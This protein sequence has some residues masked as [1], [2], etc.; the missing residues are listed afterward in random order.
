MKISEKGEIKR[1]PLT[2]VNGNEVTV[3]YAF[4]PRHGEKPG[5][6]LK[7]QRILA[8]KILN[9]GFKNCFGMEFDRR[10]VEKGIHGKPFWKPKKGICFNVSNTEGLVVCAVAR[11][12]VGVDGEKV[13]KVRIPVVRRCCSLKEQRYILGKG[14]EEM[15]EAAY[16]RFFQIW[17]LK[18]SYIKMTGA[19]MS[20][21]VEQIEFDVMEKDCFGNQNG[22]FV[23][24]QTGD[25]W[26]SL[27]TEEEAEIV[28]Q[29]FRAESETALK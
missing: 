12:E 18:E 3:Y 6:Y 27:C 26:I 11:C 23:Q 7:H 14:Q 17:T 24:R 19:G 29:E 20:F 2:G 4:C 28:W 9:Y 16:S 25:Y 21:P 1:V 22:Y 13:K 10:K 5:E 15:D 8:D